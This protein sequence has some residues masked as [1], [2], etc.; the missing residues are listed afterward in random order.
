MN[1]GEA[2]AR[3][4]ARRPLRFLRPRWWSLIE[5]AHE[6]PAGVSMP[7]ERPTFV[8]WSR[9]SL[10][11]GLPRAELLHAVRRG[12]LQCDLLRCVG[13][14]TAASRQLGRASCR[15]RV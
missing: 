15:E 9:E 14:G 5:R 8:L 11:K 13:P 2:R 1:A 6:E 10:T 4:L 7:A 3:Q 12:S